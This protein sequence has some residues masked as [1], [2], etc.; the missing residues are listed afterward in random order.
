MTALVPRMIRANGGYLEADVALAPATVIFAHGSGSSRHSPRNRAVASA[1]MEIGVGVVL[2][3]LLT[4]AETVRDA[5]DESRRYDIGLLAD[6]VCAAINW[7]HAQMEEPHHGAI[8]LY[9]AST[10]AA[11]ALIAAAQMPEH[12]GAIVS[13]GGRP[14][15]AASVLPRVRAPLRFIVG[16]DD[17]AVRAINQSSARQLTCTNDL[18]VVPGAGHLFEEPGAMDAVVALA[19]EWFTRHLTTATTE[20]RAPAG[21]GVVMRRM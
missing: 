9:G 6:R 12:V 19:C 20:T 14:D 16:G 21:A 18:V 7:T 8:G 13:R 4:P 5:Q 15:L 1:L 17:L 3:D 2:V 11:A 10:G